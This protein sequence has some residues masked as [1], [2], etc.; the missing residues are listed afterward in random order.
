ME[1]VQAIAALCTISGTAHYSPSELQATQLTC[2]KYYIR[3][4]VNKDYK[5][6]RSREKEA[7]LMECIQELP[8]K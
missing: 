7:A 5:P 4:L 1:I 8:L 6:M 2:Q 3:C